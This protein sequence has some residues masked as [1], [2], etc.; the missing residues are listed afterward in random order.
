[1]S[2]GRSGDYGEIGVERRWGCIEWCW[3]GC[4]DLVCKFRE[5]DG[6][7]RML[8]QSTKLLIQTRH[9]KE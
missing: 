7:A 5:V 2:E 8:F 3:I 6:C 9:N 4:L 1:M